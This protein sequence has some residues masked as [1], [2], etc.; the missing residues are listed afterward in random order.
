MTAASDRLQ[1][2]AERLSESRNERRSAYRSLLVA[3]AV[4]VAVP[5]LRT[6]FYFRDYSIIWEGAYRLLLGQRPYVDFGLPLGPVALWMG[7]VGMKLQGPSFATLRSV[8]VVWNVVLTLGLFALFR[9]WRI[10]GRRFQVIFWTAIAATVLPLAYLWYN[11]VGLGLVL[12]AVL[13]ITWSRRV[14]RGE[15]LAVLAG[16]CITLAVFAKQDFGGLGLAIIVGSLAFSREWRTLAWFVAGV[17]VSAALMLWHFAGP[18]FAY[19]FNHGQPPHSSQLVRLWYRRELDDLLALG[20][21]LTAL[22]LWWRKRD[23]SLLLAGGFVV[24]ALI[25]RRTSGLPSITGTYFLPF[26]VYI[27]FCAHD[28]WNARRSRWIS[29]V[30]VMVALLAGQR[31]LKNMVRVAS[32]LVTRAPM[33]FDLSP[34]RSTTGIGYPPDALKTFRPMRLPAGS[35]A[36]VVSLTE[37]VRENRSGR[38]CVLLN[39]S[40]YSPLYAA[41]GCTPPLHVPLWFHTGFTF[42]DREEADV[43]SRVGKGEFDVVLVQSVHDVPS[44]RFDELAEFVAASGRYDRLTPAVV[45]MPDGYPLQIFV[46]RN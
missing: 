22:G 3:I 36:A 34:A 9:E 25:T 11:G 26:G 33:S 41:T 2:T 19:W 28:R 5:L 46:R 44:T 40:E 23:I 31:T 17:A 4:A 24:S 16:G 15:L 13:A 38:P 29:A 42:W 21:A 32:N 6:D 27:L 39:I 12:I 37:W 30:M 8:A 10:D 20:A 7:W 14:R 18:E 45:A 1:H 35:V 43:R